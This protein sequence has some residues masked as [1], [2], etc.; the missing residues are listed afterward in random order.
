MNRKAKAR[1]RKVRSTE[2]PSYPVRKHVKRNATTHHRKHKP[3]GAAV[4]KNVSL[5]K[6]TPPRGKPA[7]RDNYTHMCRAQYIKLHFELN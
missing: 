4:W 1:K 2:S 6:K 3:T 5:Y 7:S